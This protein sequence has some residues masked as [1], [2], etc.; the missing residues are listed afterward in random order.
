M[1]RQ[2]GSLCCVKFSRSVTVTS[3]AAKRDEALKLGAHDIID[4]RDSSALQGIACRFDLILSTVNAKLDWNT[5]LSILKPRGRLHLVG[6]ALEP[7]DVHVFPL[8]VGQRSVSGS[9]VGSPATI[10]RMLEFAARHQIKPVT[11][12]FRFDQVNEA[13]GHLASGAARYRVV[14]SR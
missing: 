10:K 1:R 14:L 5:Y 4:S 8:L 13:I 2:M 12:H 6:A 9:P 11:E 7:L 3:S